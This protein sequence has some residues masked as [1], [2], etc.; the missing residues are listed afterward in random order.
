MAQHHGHHEQEFLRERVV[1]FTIEPTDTAAQLLA[2]MAHTGFQGRALGQAADLWCQMLQE[3]CTIYLTISGA[4]VPAG[5][6]RLL[7]YLIEHRYVDCVVST[8]AQLFHDLGESLGEHHFQAPHAEAFDDAVLRRGD[9][10][11]MYDVLWSHHGLD[12]AER[13]IAEYAATLSPQPVTTREFLGGLGSRLIQEGQQPG[14]LTAAAA[15]GVPVYCPALGDSA[16]G[17]ALAQARV[18]DGITVQF[19]TVQDVVETVGIVGATE[20]A[21]GRTALII[22]GGGTPRNFA[23]QTATGADIFGRPWFKMHKYGIQI[24]TD[25]PQWGGLSG[26][27]FEEAKSWGKYDLDQARTATVYAEATIVLPLLATAVVER[28]QQGQ[29]RRQKPTFHFAAHPLPVRIEFT[30]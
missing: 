25:S 4:M 28:T 16:I 23:Q 10:V 8:A 27:T 3:P 19:D 5:M 15:A 22:I 17:T 7:A 11:R 14:I 9:I 26:S 21:G 2:K 29:P 30:A 1:P 13:F 24:T 6:G 18:T 20:D 12:R